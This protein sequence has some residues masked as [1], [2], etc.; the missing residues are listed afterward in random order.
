LSPASACHSSGATLSS[1]SIIENS[2][3]ATPA[4]SHL[5]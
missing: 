1:E 3:S 4:S 5:M 2:A